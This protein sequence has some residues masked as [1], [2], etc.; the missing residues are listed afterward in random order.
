MFPKICPQFPDVLHFVG[1]HG[2]VVGAGGGVLGGGGR[3]CGGLRMVTVRPY[4]CPA[5]R[6]NFLYIRSPTARPFL[7]KGEWNIATS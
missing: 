6:R 1:D 2:P 4:Q 3:F 7:H 5:G